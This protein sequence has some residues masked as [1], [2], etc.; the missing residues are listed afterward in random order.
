MRAVGRSVVLP[1]RRG[2]VAG[3]G[4]VGMCPS[5]LEQ[6]TSYREQVLDMEVNSTIVKG[7]RGSRHAPPCVTD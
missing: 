2:L 6:R 5:R 3:L 4:L 1:Q 7:R